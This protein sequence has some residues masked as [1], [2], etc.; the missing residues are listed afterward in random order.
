M[1]M[2]VVR[3][4]NELLIEEI[5]NQLAEATEYANRLE[6]SWMH[7]GFLLVQCKGKEAWKGLFPSFNDYMLDL[8]DRYGRGR[9]QLFGYMSAS[10]KLLPSV[11][12]KVLEE[13]GI[14]K[15]HELKRVLKYA[16]EI[17]SVIIEVAR[18]NK[19]TSKELRAL[20]GQTYNAPPDE[21]GSWMDLDGFFV[22]LE[23]RKEFKEC[24]RVTE[25]VL[26]INS[27]LPD[28]ARRKLVIM[29]WVQ[30][31]MGTHAADA[32]G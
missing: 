4:E 21:K 9:T 19:T 18:Q 22:S 24:V 31:F 27:E 10:E 20:I 30:E 15:A 17:P 14:S 25:K 28:H 3:S 13:I 29:A 8:R 6:S 2:L 16:T 5:N 11:P 12:A 7:I 32:N 1:N 23:E 26:E